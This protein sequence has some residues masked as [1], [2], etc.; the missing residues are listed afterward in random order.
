MNDDSKISNVTN[1]G[2]I[3]DI[4]NEHNNYQQQQHRSSRSD[5]RLFPISTYTEQSVSLNASS[6][7]LSIPSSESTTK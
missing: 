4:S 3:E 5:S 7:S 1:G 2:S 6:S